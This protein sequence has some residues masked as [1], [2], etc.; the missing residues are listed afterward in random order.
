MLVGSGAAT[1]NQCEAVVWKVAAEVGCGLCAVLMLP[2]IKYNFRI[3]PLQ[4]VVAGVT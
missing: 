3:K 2:L 4:P 1:G